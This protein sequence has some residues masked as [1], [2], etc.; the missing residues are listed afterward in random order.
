MVTAYTLRKI[1]YQYRVEFNELARIA[2]DS[3]E[4]SPAVI[5]ENTGWAM[6]K[7]LDVFTYAQIAG[8]LEDKRISYI[9]PHEKDAGGVSD[10]QDVEGPVCED[11]ICEQRELV[12]GAQDEGQHEQLG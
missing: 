11:G 10:G 1:L 6:S 2:K 9:R 4:I 12:Q 3:K 5:K 8:L 7:C